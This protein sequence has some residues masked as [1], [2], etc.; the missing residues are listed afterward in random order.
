MIAATISTERVLDGLPLWLAERAKL[1]APELHG[2]FAEELVERGLPLWRS[3]LGLELLHPE[4]SGIRTI[5]TRDAGV[6]E[7]HAPRGVAD[8][9]AY[10]NSPVRIADETERPFRQKLV[11]LPSGLPLLREL[12]E[13]GGTDYVIY[14][15]PFLDRSRSAY[16]SFVSDREA[17]FAEAELMTLSLAAT[18]F[19]PYVERIALRRMAIDLLDI[20]VGHYAGE[21]IFRGQIRRGAVDVIEAAILMCDLRG[22]TVLSNTHPREVVIET[23]N[24]W[25]DAVADAVG[26]HNGEILKFMGDGLLAIFRSDGEAVAACRRALDAASEAR[27]EIARLDIARAEAGAPTIDFVMGLHIGDVAYGNVGGRARL[28][29]TVLGPAVNYANRLQELAKQLGE[30]VLVSQSVAACAAGSLV[31]LGDHALRGI[32]EAER[33]FGLPAP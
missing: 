13:A 22:F 3:S 31:D 11:G 23:L 8:T 32:G 24:A 16:L 2:A 26:A 17:G 5:W 21:R 1:S 15:L 30:K 12:Q 20:Y 28:D 9:P 25:F 14:P 27:A 29:F 33:V 4:Q 7:T 19:S 18:F 6:S 10:L